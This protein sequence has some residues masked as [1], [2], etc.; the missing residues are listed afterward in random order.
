VPFNRKTFFDSVRPSLFG[1]SLSQGQVN[2][3]NFK[4]DQWR[5]KM[6]S[7]DPRTAAYCLATSYHETGAMMEPV[8]EGFCKSD[9]E[10]RAYVKKNGYDYAAVDPVT[11]EVYYGRGDIQCT[12]GDNYKKAGQN[13]GRGDSLYLN[14]E[15]MLDDKISADCLFQGMFDGWYRKSSDGKRQTLARYFNDTTDDPYGAREIV[16]GD[17]SKVPSWSNGVSIGNLI[18]G[19]HVKFLSAI[20]AAWTEPVPEPE[21]PAPTPEPAQVLVALT[22]PEG[23]EVIVTVNGVA[24]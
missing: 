14:P 8:R 24:V 15:L 16:N 23:T 11:G 6:Y 5:D 19:Y 12:W 17:K 7:T 4:M 1:G 22:V 21:P 18:K 3:M 2:G 10:A 20:N 13:T 9:E